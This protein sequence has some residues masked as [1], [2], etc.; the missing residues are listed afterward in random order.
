M[1]PASNHG[2]GGT[3]GFPDVCA[4][5]P[6]GAPIPYPN[7]GLWAM[8]V[9]FAI[10]TYLSFVN[11]INLGSV[12]LLTMGDQAGVMSPFMG[13]ALTTMGNPTV[14]IEGLPAVNLLCPTTGNNMINALGCVA[15]PSVTNVFFTHA[16]APAPG[17]IDAEAL[18]ALAAALR[19]VDDAEAALPGGVVY[20][21][22]S[23]FAAPLPSRIH[24]LLRRLGPA[25]ALI[26]DLRGCPGGDLAAAIELAGDFLDEGSIVAS[27]VDGDGDEIVYRARQ[28]M[29]H[30]FPL[31]LLIDRRTGSAAEVFAAALKAHGRAVVIGEPSFGKGSVQRVVPG[32]SEPGAHYLTVATTVAPD[33]AP[34][35]GR[36]VEPDVRVEPSPVA[37]DFASP[38]GIAADPPLCTALAMAIAAA[39]LAASPS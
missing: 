27:V 31:A 2:M 36:G 12:I 15:V 10:K 7:L 33:G 34:L 28:P 16:G 11:A 32:L 17:S 4:T 8:S 18:A 3:F 5:P 24:D 21:A 35:D 23:L 13:P 9:P 25:R 39:D 37:S 29:P 19:P 22:I 1:L 38:E 14:F 26:V 20:A 6:T 30:R